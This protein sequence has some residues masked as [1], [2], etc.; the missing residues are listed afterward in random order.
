L[1]VVRGSIAFAFALLGL[2][3]VLRGLGPLVVPSAYTWLLIVSGGAW[4]LAFAIFTT[5]YSPILS[6]PR[7]DGKEG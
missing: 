1:L 2:A 6:S 7:V 5:V 3:T 4:T